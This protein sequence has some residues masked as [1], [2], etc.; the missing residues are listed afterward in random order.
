MINIIEN[1]YT[2]LHKKLH[3]LTKE[4]NLSHYASSLSALN[5]WKDIRNKKNLF[6]GKPFGCQGLFVLDDLIIPPRS[7]ITDPEIFPYDFISVDETLGTILSVALPFKEANVF[8]TDSFFTMG[9]F[10]E[11][12]HYLSQN[13]DYYSNFNIYVDFNN[14]GISKLNITI[15]DIIKRMLAFIPENQDKVNFFIYDFSQYS[16]K[17]KYHHNLYLK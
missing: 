3:D 15:D 5:I 9:E 17:D 12:L 14:Y 7:I 11:N 16:I 4:Y 1:G 13:I 10:Y 6:I 8:L 2:P